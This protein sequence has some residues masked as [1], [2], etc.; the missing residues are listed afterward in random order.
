MNIPANMTKEQV[1]ELN[2][3]GIL[4]SRIRDMVSR[5][6]EKEARYGDLKEEVVCRMVVGLLS[7][8]QEMLPQDDDDVQIR[9]ANKMLNRAKFILIDNFTKAD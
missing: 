2:S 3:M 8:V 4:G 6:V 5:Q 1:F 9:M 7:D